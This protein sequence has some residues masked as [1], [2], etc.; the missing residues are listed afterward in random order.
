MYKFDLYIIH[1][2]GIFQI[3]IH[4]NALFELLSHKWIQGRNFS[5]SPAQE[6]QRAV[7]LR[8]CWIVFWR[9]W[10]GIWRGENVK[11]LCSCC[12]CCGIPKGFP[13]SSPAPGITHVEKCL[14]REKKLIKNSLQL[15]WSLKTPWL[16]WKEIN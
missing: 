8:W 10:E 12:C 2:I 6:Q 16:V 1:L 4:C 14:L 5:L 9:N 7:A 13:S 3:S 15:S 11:I